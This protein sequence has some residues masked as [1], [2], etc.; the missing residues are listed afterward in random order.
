MYKSINLEVRPD[1]TSAVLEGDPSEEKRGERRGCPALQTTLKRHF[2]GSPEC[3][4]QIREMTGTWTRGADVVFCHF[5][6]RLMTFESASDGALP[7][8]NNE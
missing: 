4:K 1:Q 3:Q 7:T 8:M 6:L 5:K 2:A